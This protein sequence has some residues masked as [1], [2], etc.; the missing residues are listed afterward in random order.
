MKQVVRS[1]CEFSKV[2]L[3]PLPS[4]TKERA[5]DRRKD[6]EDSRE[7]F[8]KSIDTNLPTRRT[9]KMLLS[10]LSLSSSSLTRRSS[11]GLMTVKSSSRLHRTED[12][13]V[14]LS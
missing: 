1:S 14:R 11:L 9:D 5:L 7:D 3:E 13:E 4:G 12:S 10:S 2:L 8:L 6:A